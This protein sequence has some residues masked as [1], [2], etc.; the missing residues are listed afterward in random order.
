MV[1]RK[2]RIFG[3]NDPKKKDEKA[4]SQSNSESVLL[5]GKTT[6]QSCS[7]TTLTEDYWRQWIMFSKNVFI[8]MKNYRQSVCMKK[9]TPLRKLINELR[10]R[11]IARTRLRNIRQNY[12]HQ[13]WKRTRPHGVGQLSHEVQNPI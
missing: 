1:H 9:N 4:Q 2:R 3:Y 11:L 6:I 10:Q 13:R 12:C 5:L 7:S 8:F